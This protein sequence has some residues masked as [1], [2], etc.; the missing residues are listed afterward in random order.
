LFGRG[1][2]IQKEK[3][4]FEGGNVSWRIIRGK[5]LVLYFKRGVILYKKKGENSHRKGGRRHHA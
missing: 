4:L 3:I 1:I 5:L 2:R